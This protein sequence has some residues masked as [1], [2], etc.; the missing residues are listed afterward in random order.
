[1]KGIILAGG[2]GT[3]LA[4]ITKHINKHL[5]PVYDKPMI[6]Y[7]LSSLMLAGI[8]DILLISTPKDKTA[9]QDLLGD[10][11]HLGLNIS[12]AEQPRPEGLAQAFI[13]GESFIGADDVCLILGDNLFYGQGLIEKLENAKHKLPGAVTFAYYVDEPQRYGVVAFDQQNRVIDIVEKPANPP[14]HYAVTGIYFYDSRAVQ[15]AKSL[16]PSARGEL[17]ITDLNRMYLQ[18]GALHV[19]L[20]GRGYAWLDTGTSQSLMEASQFVALIEKR[21]GLK[22]GCPE[23]I[24]WRKG[25]ISTKQLAIL[26]EPLKKSE[27]GQYLLKLIGEQSIE[28]TYLGTLELVT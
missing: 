10:G 15:F 13:I 6:Y 11:S 7:P 1:M 9:Y 8:R 22:V 20:L 5:L 2:S 4:P 3:R 23:E 14:S 25:Y 18:Q 12:Y 17:E 16:K 28:K 19:E 21:Q 27:Y 24:A 26:A